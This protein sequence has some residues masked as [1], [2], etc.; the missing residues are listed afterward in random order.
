MHTSGR[1]QPQKHPA[2]NTDSRT[3][4]SNQTPTTQNGRPATHEHSTLSQNHTV[5]NL[6]PKPRASAHHP[7]HSTAAGHHQ[8][9]ITKQHVLRPQTRCTVQSKVCHKQQQ[10]TTLLWGGRGV[11]GT[12]QQRLYT[13]LCTAARPISFNSRPLRPGGR[14]HVFL[15]VTFRSRVKGAR[16][17]SSTEPCL[18]ADCINDPCCHTPQG[19]RQ[20]AALTAAALCPHLRNGRP[21]KGASARHT[22]AQAT[23]HTPHMEAKLPG[24][25]PVYCFHT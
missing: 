17:I 14:M 7:R 9:S 23:P 24:Q 3:I 2:Q 25:L 1:T 13:P 11:G 18:P 15:R 4:S 5:H 10:T 8:P 19:Q 16:R 20:P 12:R 6:V 22:R 21:A